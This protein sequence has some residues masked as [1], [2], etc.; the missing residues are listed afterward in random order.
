MILAIPRGLTAM[1]GAMALALSVQAETDDNLLD[2]STTDVR[3]GDV[4]LAA[5]ADQWVV[6]N[7]W[8]TWCKPCLKEIPD[9]SD[10]HDRRSDVTLLG[11]TFEETTAQDVQT[12]LEKHPAS[13]PVALVDVFDPPT[14]FGTPKVLPTTLLIAPDGTQRKRFVGPVTSEM[15]ET[16]IAAQPDFGG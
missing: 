5:L 16:E 12:F 1:L 4:D 6:I 7:F 15:I 9:L 3:G 11:L 2:F 8:A 10:L 14:Q 13:Y